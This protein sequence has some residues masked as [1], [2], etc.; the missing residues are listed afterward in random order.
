MVDLTAAALNRR[1]VWQRAAPGNDGAVLG[2][3]GTG[4]VSALGG[5]VTGI[6]VGDEVVI[7]PSVGWGDARGR[8]GR[9]LGDPG[10]PPP[11][12]L[13]RADRDPGRLRA[14]AARIG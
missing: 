6:A 9:R 11:G 3:D 1:D 5:D 8:A 10:R 4:R 14:A 13:R 12:H 2:S 7:N